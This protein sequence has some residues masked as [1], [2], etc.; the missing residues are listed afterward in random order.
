MEFLYR[1]FIFSIS[2]S[3]LRCQETTLRPKGSCLVVAETHLT[4]VSDISAK[5]TDMGLR[6]TT[7][8]P[9]A[10]H[11]LRVPKYRRIDIWT[12]L[13]HH[14]NSDLLAWD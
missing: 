1:S 4:D 5:I 8:A 9:S 2:S 11:C 12:S 14:L 7:F 6:I 10:D 3:H 13:E